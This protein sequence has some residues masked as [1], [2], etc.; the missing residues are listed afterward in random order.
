MYKTFYA[1]IRRKCSSKNFQQRKLQI[2]LCFLQYFKAW[3][4][5]VFLNVGGDPFLIR[6]GCGE[7]M[8]AEKPTTAWDVVSSASFVLKTKELLDGELKALEGSDKK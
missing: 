4:R 5:E 2:L 8:Y 7:S 1:K 3:G 6:E